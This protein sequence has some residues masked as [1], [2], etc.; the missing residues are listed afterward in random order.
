MEICDHLVLLLFRKLR[1]FLGEE[2][3]SEVLVKSLF[4]ERRYRD[5]DSFRNAADQ[6][7]YCLIGL[8]PGLAEAYHQ[9]AH[10]G[11]V[12]VCLAA[13]VVEPVGEPQEFIDLL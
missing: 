13:D 11:H 5:L 7:L 12:H 1:F 10:D 6:V 9:R 4:V 2:E 8:L 3:A